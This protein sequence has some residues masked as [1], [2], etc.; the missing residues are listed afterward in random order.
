LLD[1]WKRDAQTAPN[2]SVWKTDPPRPAQTHPFPSDLPIPLREALAARKI[3]SLY[4]HQLAAWVLARARR[5]VILAT[6]TASGK[7][8]AYNL[9]VL[10][11]AL[12]DPEARALY[13]FPTKALAQDQLSALNV[14]RST[15]NVPSAVYD[16]DT[17]QNHRPSI[18]KNARIVLSN[19]DMLHTGILPHHVH[20]ADFF[21]RLKFVVIDEAHVYRGVF[22]SHVANVI[23]RLKR[24]AN[25]YGA[26]PQFILASATIGNP[27]ELAEAL[28]EE[29]VELIDDD[30]SP[31]GER[32]FLIYNPPVTDP[33]L[34]LR[35]SGLLE[36]ARLAADLFNHDIQSIV[37]ARTR[38]SVEIILTHLQ[39]GKR[40]MGNGSQPS[41]VA[42]SPSPI[43]GYR[44]GYLPRQRRE[45]ERGL[46]DGS[47]KVVVATSALELGVDIGGLGAAVIVGYS[48]TIASARQQSGRAG[49]GD[50]PCVSVLVVSPAPL[51]QFLARHPDYFFDASPEQALV[52]PN[53]PLI[54]LEHLRCALFELPFK[55]GEGFGNVSNEALEEYLEFMTE[56]RDAHFSNAAYYW[57]KDQYPAA[58][59]SLRSVSPQSV[60]LQSVTEDGRP[61]TIGAVDGESAAWMVHPGAIYLHEGQQYFVQEYDIENRAAQLIPVALDYYTEARRQS[62]IQVTEVGER[63]AVRGGEKARGEI[64]V[65]TQVVGFRKLRWFTLENLGEEPL[66]MPPSELHTTGYW[67]SLSEATLSRL[68]E[69]GNWSNDPNQY[70]PGWEQI[71]DR[72]RERDG[73]RCQVCGAPETT[74]RHDVHHKIPFRLFLS[75]A[76][77]SE[78]AAQN[79]EALRSAI[80]KA[81]RLD[82]L[83]TLCNRCHRKAEQNVRIRSG[84]AGLGFALG[85]LAPLFLM[86]DPRDL[87]VHADPDWKPAN[88]LP[89]V[90][91]YD[92]VPAGIGFSQRLF[93]IHDDLIL[94]ALELVGAC[95]CEDGCPSCVG[96]GGENG[97]GGKAETLAILRELAGKS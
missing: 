68:R 25:F 31:R 80:E 21:S 64:Q 93:E 71:R 46:R 18:R 58:N 39:D 69:S 22:G 60:V 38:R 86:C 59:V 26:K 73:Y 24:A 94:R 13:L 57:M 77:S 42:H 2:I 9:P 28:V 92:L 62:E 96:P 41:F 84:L 49:R 66:D 51:D 78:A 74:R 79:P 52:N 70:G 47:V 8:L 29:D 85:N 30:G 16:G 34:G 27:K 4:S 91:L 89:S 17:P 1:F 12:E 14:E 65:T 90:V 20:W 33:A 67:L 35:K 5:N 11:A 36:S 95:G 7:T 61:T 43:R 97:A 19:P 32:H 15:L 88:G 54:L 63:A 37:F 23:R 6:G 48:G 10:A 55:K 72:A 81:N 45:I 76:A 82:N 50:S 83:A 75:K 87:G 44:S 40:R 3:S 56:S 53:H